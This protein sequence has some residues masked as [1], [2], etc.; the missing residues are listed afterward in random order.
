MILRFYN[1][2]ETDP[3]VIRVNG[4]TEQQL[5]LAIRDKFIQHN[6][7]FNVTFSDIEAENIQKLIDSGLLSSNLISKDVVGINYNVNPVISDENG[8]L[9]EKEVVHS[10]PPARNPN[11]TGPLKDTTE[12]V[13]RGEIVYEN[14]FGEE[15][16]GQGVEIP[17]EPKK[18][19]KKVQAPE[20]IE[21][22][23]IKSIKALVGAVEGVQSIKDTVTGNISNLK[24][25]TLITEPKEEAP[26]LNKP[27]KSSPKETIK[28]NGLSAPKATGN[29][30]RKGNTVTSQIAVEYENEI[31]NNKENCK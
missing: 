21:G 23:K 3:N 9:V 20:N 7:P 2:N 27:E 30:F 12:R 26:V 18:V 29:P 28:K 5:F 19:S 11:V 4:L 1:G 17:K 10:T 15:F 6:V 25:L 14:T 31:E 24:T 8:N 13:D 16:D 22:T